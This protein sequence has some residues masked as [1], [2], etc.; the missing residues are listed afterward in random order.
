VPLLPAFLSKHGAHRTLIVHFPQPDISGLLE[1]GY[2]GVR[3]TKNLY[4][5]VDILYDANVFARPA[6]QQL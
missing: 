1:S 3:Q 4:A 5:F 6:A 2:A